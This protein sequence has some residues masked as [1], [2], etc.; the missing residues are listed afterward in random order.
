M[1][2]LINQI[3]TKPQAFDFS[4]S[5]G[6]KVDATSVWFNDFEFFN[7]FELLSIDGDSFQSQV[8]DCCGY[9]GCSSGSWISLRKFGE[10][11]LFAPAIE[12]MLEGKWEID[13]YGPPYCLRKHGVPAF[14]KEK[15]LKLKKMVPKLPKPDAILPM[16]NLEY[17]AVLQLEAPGRILGNLGDPISLN[18]NIIIAVNEGELNELIAIFEQL[19][20]L[21]QSDEPAFAPST[22]T[23]EIEFIL[24]FPNFPS[25]KPMAYFDGK[26]R[27]HLEVK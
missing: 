16:K 26:P 1:P 10:L 25:W 15:Y 4:S 23:Q 11:Y 19:L 8:C 18:R 14:S 7:A 2:T 17:F 5:G 12:E 22:A 9:V 21:G 20:Q 13:E 27:L 3:H 6:G 24:D